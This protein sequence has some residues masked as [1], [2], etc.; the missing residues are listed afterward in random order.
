ME[1]ANLSETL[2]RWVHMCR[3]FVPLNLEHTGVLPVLE[4]YGSKILSRKA[5]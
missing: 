5:A 3:P 1:F 4:A 2:V